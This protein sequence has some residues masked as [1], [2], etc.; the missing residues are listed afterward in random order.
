MLPPRIT[1]TSS[2]GFARPFLLFLIVS[3]LAV[4]GFGFYTARLPFIPAQWQNT[5]SLPAP[6]P[7]KGEEPFPLG[8]PSQKAKSAKGSYTFIE[9]HP[10][11]Q[12]ITYSPC[13]PIRY[14]LSEVFLP[15]DGPE[16]V[17]RALG[18]ISKHSGFV[19]EFA[20]FTSERPRAGREPYQPEMYPDQWAPVLVGW[21]DAG[22]LDNF[23][24][25]A[26]GEATSTIVRPPQ[27]DPMFVSGQ[28][29][30]SME[31]W[32]DS[33]EDLRTDLLLHEFAHLIGL[34]HV[35]DDKELMYPYIPADGKELGDGDLAGLAALHQ[36]PCSSA[37]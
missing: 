31:T 19:F 13:R 9:Q 6:P 24:G 21:V 8:E 26:I 36:S 10:S 2:G 11:G 34:A 17:E 28:V 29:G 12:A 32:E 3:L 5:T 18:I 1:R 23:Q 30:V 15:A 16:I 22:R 37:V 35:E 4:I 25:E 33:S 27:S 7:G 20:G 14:V